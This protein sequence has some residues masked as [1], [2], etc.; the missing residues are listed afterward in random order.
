MRAAMQVHEGLYMFLISMV[1]WNEWRNNNLSL[2]LSLYLHHLHSCFLPFKCLRVRRGVIAADVNE[3]RGVVVSVPAR[4]T[5]LRV[6]RVSYLRA[7]FSEKGTSP[8]YLQRQWF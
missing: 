3:E 1:R 4:F 6:V 2:S 5:Y 8:E 7:N